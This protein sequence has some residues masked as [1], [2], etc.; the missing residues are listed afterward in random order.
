MESMKPIGQ[1]IGRLDHESCYRAVR[2]RDSRFDGVFYTAVRTTGIYCRPS[3]PAVTPKRANVEF[4]PTAAA[5]HDHGYRACKRCRPDASPGSPEWD[6]RKDA[7]ARAM[8]LVADGV[9]DREGVGGLAKRLHYSTRHLNRIIS[10]ELGAGPLAIARAQRAQTSRILIET[11]DVPF[12][13]IA[14]AAG[15]GSVRQFNDTVRA[16][17]DASPSDLRAKRQDPTASERTNGS[18]VVDLAVRQPFDLDGVLAFLA[19][20]TIPG[21]ESVGPDGYRRS[22]D[23]PHGHGV[24]HVRPDVVVKSGRLHA[25][26]ELRLADWRDLAP[27][28]SRIRRLLDLDADP[29]AIEQVLAAD[30]R[31]APLVGRE[32]GRRVPGSVDP[33]ETVVRAVVGQQISVSGA[34]TVVG[35]IVAAVGRPLAVA[36]DV[37]THVFPSPDALADIDEALLPMPMRRRQ[38]LI[39]LGARASLGKIPLDVGADRDDVRAALLD[40]PGVGPWTADYVLMRGFGDPDI[41]LPTD[42]GVKHGLS[43]LGLPPDAADRWRPWRS[44]ALHHLWAAL[45]PHPP[46]TTTPPTRRGTP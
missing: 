32:P 22:L 37:L 17:F 44:Y 7:V 45:G 21:V 14:F 30:P 29:A 39:E 41:F 9:V 24:A 5:A 4:F 2:S 35:R 27:A 31:M 38:T 18:V 3:C 11:T 13:A 1:G 36:D 8:R 28:V 46:T 12:T 42:L 16:V 6:V 43:L 19:S 34:R 26:V 20:R 15:F 33:F 25:R 23:L 10:S 40:V